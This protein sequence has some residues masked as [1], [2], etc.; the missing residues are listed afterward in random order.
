MNFK[1]RG[2]TRN[3]SFCLLISYFLTFIVYYLANY[4]L[5]G[6]S[7]LAYLQM[8]LNKAIY[9]AIPF[10]ASL[11]ALILSSFV[12]TKTALI[13]LIPLS[14]TRFIYSLPL[15]YLVFIYSSFD[16][17]DSILLSLPVSILECV[18]IYVLSLGAFLLMRFIIRKAGGTKSYSEALSEKT[19]LDFKHPVSL[20]FAIISLLSFALIFTND[21]VSIIELISSSGANLKASE[22]FYAV[23]LVIYDA[24]L[25]FLQYFLLSFIKNMVIKKRVIKSDISD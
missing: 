8:I 16:T 17:F 7:I 25:L 10:T 9:L 2:L 1:S 5:Y 21:A 18:F 20:A 11:A 14:L 24:A 19:P 6:N 4:I 23:F 13:S 22:I 15:Y 12:S 3:V